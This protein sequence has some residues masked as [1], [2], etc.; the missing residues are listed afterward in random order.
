MEETLQKMTLDEKVGQLLVPHLSPVFMN[1]ESTTFQEIERNIRQFH[2]GG[3]YAFGGDSAT[4]ALLLNRMQGLA[5]IPLLITADLEG[6]PGYKYRGATRLP[7][8]MALGATGSEELVYQ[9]ARIAA[10]EGRALGIGV[11]FY[12]VA[13]VNNNPRN[14]II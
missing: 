2:V 3:Y 10:V 12:P 4:L 9:A 6:G 5:K 11:N 13:D 7:R 8:A 14:P 1:R